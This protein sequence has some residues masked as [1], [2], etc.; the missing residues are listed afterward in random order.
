VCHGE[1]LRGAGDVPR[2]AG[3][4]PVYIARQLFFMQGGGHVGPGVDLMQP[5]VAKLSEEDI[6][7]I[8]AYLG[9]LPPH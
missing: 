8:S 7:A 2:L 1:A 9:S 5:A 6:I 4:Q 3:L